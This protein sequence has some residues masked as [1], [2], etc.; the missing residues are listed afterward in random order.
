MRFIE[1]YQT[2]INQLMKSD[3]SFKVNM[4]KELIEIEDIYVD[5]EEG[6]TNEPVCYSVYAR[7]R[8]RSFN[9]DE[10]EKVITEIQELM[11]RSD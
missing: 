1:E 10:V 6:W 11:V 3:I 7:D 8:G 5:V 2:I 9:L 4:E